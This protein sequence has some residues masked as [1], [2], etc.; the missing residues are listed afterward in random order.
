MHPAEALSLGHIVNRN[1]ATELEE[2][3]QAELLASELESLGHEIKIRDLNSGLHLILIAD[4]KLIGAAD[5]RREG[6]A[7][8]K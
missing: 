4:D 8:G 3:T 5:P 7:K 6:I 1:G 2:I